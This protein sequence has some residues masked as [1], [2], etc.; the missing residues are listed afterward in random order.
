MCVAKLKIRL[1]G[2]PEIIYEDQHLSVKRRQIRSLLLYLAAHETLVGRTDLMIKF[3]KD[4]EDLDESTERRRIRKM[5]SFLREALP[6]PTMLVTFNDQVGLD[7]KRVE[8]DVILFQNLYQK[9]ENT[10]KLHRMGQS[11][12]AETVYIM[13]EAVSLWQGS[14][15]FLQSAELMGSSEL[16]NWQVYMDSRL[17]NM[18]ES[19]INHLALNALTIGDYESGARWLHM[20]LELNQFSNE[21]ETVLFLSALKKLGRISEAFNIAALLKKRYE[22]NVM[23]VSPEL[24]RVCNEILNQFSSPSGEESAVWGKTVSIQSPFVGRQK[25]LTVLKSAY[26]TKSGAVIWGEVGQ[27]KTRLAYEFYQSISHPPR[28]MVMTCHQMEKTLP[29]QPLIDMLKQFVTPEEWQRVDSFSLAQLSYFI[30]DLIMQ[31]NRQP[32]EDEIVNIVPVL[33]FEAVHQVLLAAGAVERLFIFIDNAQWCDESSLSAFT[34]L[35]QKKFF[36]NHGFLLLTAVSDEKKQTLTA[37]V[38]SMQT[39]RMSFEVVEDGI[40]R[41]KLA[42]PELYCEELTLEPLDE[43]E[44][45]VLIKNM[46]GSVVSTETC[47]KL[48]RESSGNPFILM[49][50]LRWYIE[51]YPGVTFSE[52]PEELTTPS[53]VNNLLR[54]HLSNLD[55]Q[56]RRVLNSAA[57][58]GNQFTLD[59]VSEVSAYKRADVVNAFEQLERL[60]LVKS[61]SKYDAIGGYTFTYP[62]LR[63]ILLNEMSDARKQLK[64][65]RMAAYLESHW[66]KRMAQPAVLAQ[67]FE[68]GGNYLKAFEYWLKT[69]E[70]MRQ[71]SVPAEALAAC[72][73][74]QNLLLRHTNL[75]S[76]DQIIDLYALFG[77]T[78]YYLGDIKSFERIGWMLDV[79]ALQRKSHLLMGTALIYVSKVE[80]QCKHLD[81]SLDI[82]QDSVRHLKRST[83]ISALLHALHQEA[84]LKSKMNLLAESRAVLEEGQQLAENALRVSPVTEGVSR[85]LG[86]IENDLAQQAIFNGSPQKALVLVERAIDRLEMTFDFR[87]VARSQVTLVGILCQMG[88]ARKASLAAHRAVNFA[89]ALQDNSLMVNA[90]SMAAQAYMMYADLDEC[91][92]MLEDVHRLY[93]ADCDPEAIIRVY[94]LRSFL[95]RSLGNHQR[96]L[97]ESKRA[98]SLIPSQKPYY[99]IETWLDYALVLIE[100][101]QYEESEKYIDQSMQM[102]LENEFT[103]FYLTARTFKACLLSLKN[104]QVVALSILEE[105]SEK[106]SGRQLN[107]L[108]VIVYYF[109]GLAALRTG[110]LLVARRLMLIVHEQGEVLYTPWFQISALLVINRINILQEIN[111]ENVLKKALQLLGQMRE[112]INSESIKPEF[113]AFYLK[114][115]KELKNR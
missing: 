70:Y 28:L 17:E 47:R 53:N 110:D 36:F 23:D 39:M 40:L 32:S 35:L 85:A 96:A 104:N 27:G 3:I 102:A 30:P 80:E 11:L 88:D 68:A 90:M 67:H 105:I 25:E 2:V 38:K 48:A 24:E 66:G 49:E 74:A 93:G 92:K 44:V 43:Q 15:I 54:S 19:L 109:Y 98:I 75:F 91:W 41:S 56:L 52:I 72:K 107:Q 33:I 83:N 71:I 64:N 65:Q 100:T 95:F 51:K 115:I 14:S 114:V 76:D 7:H 58:I 84:G 87:G 37:F 73:S 34:Y 6:D 94:N 97:L 45:G 26:K 61:V 77:D 108:M 8:S 4:G 1:L 55:H 86:Y 112:N 42:L 60:R 5:L 78:L 46:T 103:A 81:R 10:I 29:F 62:R 21:E 89:T 79:L 50:T 13:T 106:V 20:A 16:E 99:R 18:R 69:A 82:I 12:P 111:D 22:E 101:E 59:S 63:S 57:V 113:E 31:S 9:V